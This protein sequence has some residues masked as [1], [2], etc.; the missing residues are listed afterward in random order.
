MYD[1]VKAVLSIAFLLSLVFGSPTAAEQHPQGRIRVSIPVGTYEIQE[2]EQ[3]H[4]VSVEGFG[5]LLIPG[6][7]DL[8]SK[9][10]ALAVP[11]GAEVVDVSYDAG[12][13]VVLDGTYDVPPASLPRVIG[14]E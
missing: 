6:K 9:I 12:Q 8:P 3:G 13:G 7:P 5:R 2:N 1:K 4:E 14:P 11:P 10:F